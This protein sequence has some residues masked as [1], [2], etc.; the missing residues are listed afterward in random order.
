MADKNLNQKLDVLTGVIDRESK[1]YSFEKTIVMEG[2]II[3]TGAF[4]AKYMGV[5]ARL[6]M[7]AIRAKLL[8]GAPTQSV[9]GATDDM[10]YMMAYLMV[11]LTKT[12]AWF[13]ISLIDDFDSLRDLYMEVYNFMQ[14]FRVQ[15]EQSTNAGSSEATT[16]EETVED[17]QRTPIATK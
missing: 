3:K 6:R 1:T 14:A 5:G 16:S 9:D 12:P 13:N 17:M 4:T 10:A 11:S 2:G 8:E 15:N 7:G